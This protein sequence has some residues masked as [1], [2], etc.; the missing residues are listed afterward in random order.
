TRELLTPGAWRKQG[1]TYE[2]ADRPPPAKATTLDERRAALIQLREAFF[3]YAD[4]H[5]GRFPPADDP[6]V[7]AD[8]WAIPG[9]P[10]LRFLA[11]PDRTRED[12]GRLLIFEPDIDGDERLVL[13]TNGVVGTMQAAE[14]RQA[15]EQGREP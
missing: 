7:P 4:A 3:K 1:W 2:L 13:L 5:E 8:L 9:W 15:L 10:G 11:V 14:I 12:A 6:A